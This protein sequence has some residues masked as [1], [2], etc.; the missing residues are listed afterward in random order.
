MADQEWAQLT[1]PVRELRT[2]REELARPKGPV[3]AAL[4]TWAL[5]HRAFLLRRFT[6]FSRGGGNWRPL[7]PDTVAAKGSSGILIDRG[8]LKMGLGAGI[9]LIR[10]DIGQMIR[11]TIGFN[12]KRKHPRSQLSIADLATIHHL[13]LGVVPARRILVPP[14]A[15]AKE[16]LKN[17]MTRVV[18]RI[19]DGK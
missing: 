6:T 10:T 7:K 18:K 15:Q 2:L 11:L 3:K 5:V 17:T 13:G 12:N 14:D 16:E 8:F 4:N 19:L 9:G 1:F